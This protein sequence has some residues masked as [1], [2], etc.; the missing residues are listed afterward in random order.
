M[1]RPW[2]LAL[3]HS[4]L[5][6]MAAQAQ[7]APP[8][9]APQFSAIL[10]APQ[11]RNAVID[12]AKH[13][14]T[15]IKHDCQSASFTP[16]PMIKVWKRP[17]FDSTGTPVAGM[18]GESIEASGCGITRKLNT[19]TTVHNAGALVTGPLAP[20]Y[21]SADPVLQLD[22]SR[23]VFAA[24]KIKVQGCQQAF[25]EN[26]Q[27][28]R[29]ESPEPTDARVTGAVLV[30]NWTIAA[31]GQTVIVEVKFIPTAGGTTI[32]AHAL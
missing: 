21:T 13:S 5:S 17:E 7:D 20:G 3:V 10:K 12:A 1:T 4:I 31:C 28:V 32:A 22:T 18:W 16:L 24:E 6:V 15:W 8:P 27:A 9:P 11:H 2:G 25:L 30:E 23:Y 19:V 29:K 14:T 26:T